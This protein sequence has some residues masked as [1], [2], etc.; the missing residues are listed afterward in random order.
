MG[1]AGVQCV[2]KERS[3]V[4]HTGVGWGESCRGGWEMEEWIMQG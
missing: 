1:H 3:G 2:I 4:G